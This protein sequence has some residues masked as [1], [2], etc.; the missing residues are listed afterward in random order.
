MVLTQ[1]ALQPNCLCLHLHQSGHSALTDIFQ[2]YTNS[3]PVLN[4]FGLYKYGACART[5]YH[6]WNMLSFVI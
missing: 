2:E 3:S 1:V 6:G 4:N 5:D